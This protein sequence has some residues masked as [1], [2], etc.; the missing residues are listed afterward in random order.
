VVL[1][2][3]KFT[4][5]NF[6]LC[7]KEDTLYGK[8][9]RYRNSDERATIG[10]SKLLSKERVYMKM[11]IKKENKETYRKIVKL[12]LIALLI[13]GTI[14]T[15]LFS[16]YKYYRDVVIRSEQ[17]DIL[18][19]VT[20]VSS[21]LEV[22]FKETD[23]YLLEILQ[24]PD[25]QEAF[26]MISKGETNNIKLMELLHRTHGDE[27]LSL[28]LIDERGGIL[29]VY[30][31]NP[32][33]A[34]QPGRDI[35]K[36]VETDADVYYVDAKIDRSVNI[37]HPVKS[38]GKTIGFVR[39]KVNAEYIY[40]VYLADY[41]SNQKGYISVKDANGI[42]LL[43]PA[44]EDLGQDVVEAR[45]NQYPSYDW[46][47]LEKIVEKQKNKET[48]VDVYHSIWPGERLRVQKISAFTP[49]NIGDTFLIIN[50]SLDYEET[51]T[52]LEGIRNVTILI[53]ILLVVAFIASIGY[54][55]AVEIKKNKLMLETRYLN[56]LN[57][58]NALLMHQARFAAMGEM[59]ATI[60]HQLKQPLNALKISLYNI[61]DYHVLQESDET[62]LKKLLASNHKFIDKMANTIDDFKFFF[63][64]QDQNTAFNIYEA[65]QFAIDLNV[66]RINYLE[67]EVNVTGDRDLQ[68]KGE[69]N[70]FSQVILNL[71]NNSIDE[72]KDMKKDRR[73][74]ISIEE[75]E[76]EI[77]IIVADN[78]GGVKD[79]ILG[80]LFEP[81]AT[82]KGDQGTG[83]GLYISKSILRE[84][85]NGDLWLE[86]IN[87]GVE[88]KIILPRGGQYEHRK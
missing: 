32:Q 54:I 2:Q 13:T 47:E 16:S 29:R 14:L 80:R 70:V 33:Y 48:G 7:F 67:I 8:K 53:S 4:F 82:T 17:K 58:K 78:G 23:Q 55:Y 3:K 77:H 19:L 21:Q 31:N 26:A 69:S 73:I 76:R 75:K 10:K 56:E 28:E 85:F 79:E 36:A 65:I 41:K 74:D 22:Y 64:P 43:H 81:Y 18:N 24:E 72:L 6:F 87:D 86:N 52:S 88:V 38:Y 66:A 37:I 12:V 30:T 62:Y 11:Q 68:I 40:E 27:Y 9:F 83:L 44:K 42:L 25:F 49:C 71:V 20:T 84:K 60:A 57:E 51:I 46:S 1:Y 63:K 50:L 5:H 35:E 39:L 34:Y 61:E 45:K 15:L 59:L